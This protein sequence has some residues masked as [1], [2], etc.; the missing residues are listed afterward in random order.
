[1]QT[2]FW[3]FPF[4]WPGAPP[5]VNAGNIEFKLMKKLILLKMAL[6]LCATSLF[7]GGVGV[8]IVVNGGPPSRIAE[9]A[10]PCPGVGFIWIGGAWAW[11]DHWV[12]EKGHWDRPPHPGAVWVPHRYD[13]HNGQHV[14]VQG[15]W[16]NHSQP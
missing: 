15:G 6:L 11:H 14:F 1:L 7:A 16:R 12:W 8:E 5:A 10:A 13:V 3:H 2:S 9:T 4:K